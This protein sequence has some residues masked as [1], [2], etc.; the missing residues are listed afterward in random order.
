MRTVQAACL[1][2]LVL[3]AACGGGVGAVE[4]SDPGSEPRHDLRFRLTEDTEQEL[5]VLV[6]VSLEMEVGGQGLPRQDLPTVATTVEVDVTEVSEEEV[7]LLFSYDDVSLEG[8]G[9]PGRAR[10]QMEGALSGLEGMSG[11]VTLSPQGVV[12]EASMTL[13]EDLDP[14]LAAM[15][16]QFR[17]Q[18]GQMVVPLPHEPVGPGASWTATTSFAFSGLASEVTATYTLREFD[19]DRYVVATE[20][21]QVLEPG[22]I[23]PEDGP[24]RMELLEGRFT[25]SG[26]AEGNLTSPVPSRV[27]VTS[28]GEMRISVETGDGQQREVLQAMELRMRMEPVS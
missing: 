20:L 5:R 16:E 15:L 27:D 2:A 22:R 7:S 4:V 24:V 11:S 3:V 28:S 1:A 23:G 9:L 14:A 21:G 19:G 12:R 26:T 13:P 10:R 6:D 17:Q 25:G 18:V 8:G